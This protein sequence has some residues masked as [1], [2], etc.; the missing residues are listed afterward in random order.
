MRTIRNLLSNPTFFILS[1]FTLLVFFTR[2][3]S[4]HTLLPLLAVEKVGMSMT[5]IGFLF[6]LMTTMNL[7]LAV[8]AGAL[9]DRFGRKAVIL[10]GAFLTLAGLSLFAYTSTVSAFF[11]AAFILGL[12]SGF[13]GSAP[14]AYAGDLAPPGRA[15]TTMGLYRTFGD[16]GLISGPLL[17]GWIS[18]VI[19][20]QFASSPGR[21][22]AMVFSG[23]LLL[24]AGLVLSWAG[25]ETAGKG[26]QGKKEA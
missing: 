10:P 11:C 14:A 25:V 21:S 24:T 3:G 26:R 12:G 4:R 20:R 9:T 19:D 22:I 16:L 7:I 18:D 15:G 13:I 5:Q 6:T 23:V 1:I 2:A 17:L 8:L